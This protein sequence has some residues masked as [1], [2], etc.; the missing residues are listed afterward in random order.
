[1][2]Q[3]FYEQSSDDELC[4]IAASGDRMAEEVLVVRYHRL[5]RI[6]CRPLFLAG[7]DNEDLLQEGM[8]GLLKAI[9]EYDSNQDAAFSTYAE[10]CIRNR[11]F[12]AIKAAQRNKH[13]PLNDSV[14]FE[15]PFFERNPDRLFHPNS[16][17]AQANPEDLIISREDLRER[18]DKLSGQL[19]DFEANILSLYLNGLSYSEMGNQIGKSTKSVDNAVQ[20][21]R[22]KLAQHLTPGDFS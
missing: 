12:S 4:K 18:M 13:C 10:V 19:S 21:I 11:L 1:M 15:T 16:Q 2:N 7:G 5:V 8:V 22:R 17:F 9:R 14:P 20:R 3:V 6:C